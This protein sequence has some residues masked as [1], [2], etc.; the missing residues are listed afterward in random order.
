M[1]RDVRMA[2][3]GDCRTTGS[4]SRRGWTACNGYR[5]ATGTLVI[6][7]VNVRDS[8]G[9]CA[10]EGFCRGPF[11]FSTHRREIRLRVDASDRWPSAWRPAAAGA[12]SDKDIDDLQSLESWSASA[13]SAC[14]ATETRTAFA[15]AM[16][17]DRDPDLDEHFGVET[18]RE[19][20]V[21]DCAT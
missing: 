9:I 18:T 14:R 19:E 11:L 12:R 10:R 3:D 4:A 8:L 13:E 5:R 1:I 16:M 21:T 2:R 6:D 15:R 7:G 17:L 20:I